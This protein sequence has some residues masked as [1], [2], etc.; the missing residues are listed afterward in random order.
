MYLKLFYYNQL[1]GVVARDHALVGCFVI[2]DELYS[3]MSPPKDIIII[4]KI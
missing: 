3:P 2:G 1:Q 4:N